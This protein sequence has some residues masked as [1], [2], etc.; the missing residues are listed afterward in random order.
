M[1]FAPKL[2]LRTALVFAICTVTL[3]NHSIAQFKSD[4]TSDN[5]DK[6]SDARFLIAPEPVIFAGSGRAGNPKCA[7]LNASDDP[8]FSHL[9]QDDEFK[10]DFGS[11]NGTFSIPNTAYS[12]TTVSSGNTMTSWSLNSAPYAFLVSAVIVKGGDQ[13]YV[14]PYNPLSAGDTGQFI[15]GSQ[16][17]ISHLTF[18]FEP[19]SG[20][21]SAPVTIAGRALTLNGYGV[22]GARIEVMNLTTGEVMMA[23]TNPFGYYAFKGVTS[24]VTYM[25]TISHKRHQFIDS[26]RTI[27]LNEDLVGL[28][29]V[30]AW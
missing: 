5:F 12:I 9:S 21:S 7:D 2:Y 30:T 29:F 1:S 17:A 23:T 10:L 3:T 14:Y 19:F 4:V 25:V 16:N 18:C 13:A 22:P 26:Q 6:T 28:D 20:P 15:T 8:R 11:P 27:T 24:E